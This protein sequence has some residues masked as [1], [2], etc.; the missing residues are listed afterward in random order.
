M[1]SKIRKAIIAV[2]A[3]VT[4]VTS[5][6]ATTVEAKAKPSVPRYIDRTAVVGFEYRGNPYE[7]SFEN[8]VYKLLFVYTEDGQ[9]NIFESDLAQKYKVGQVIK[10]HMKTQR[11]KKVTDDVVLD[12]YKYSTS[13]KDVKE[14]SGFWKWNLKIV[15]HHILETKKR[16]N[17]MKKLG[18]IN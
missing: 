8:G 5:V 9:I 2:V 4:I 10:V 18:Y 1:K 14:Y 17:L 7:G 3:A 16:Y 13:N 6:P 11:T 15:R 12:T